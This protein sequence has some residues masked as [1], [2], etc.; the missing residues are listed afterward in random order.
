MKCL[1]VKKLNRLEPADEEAV[2]ALRTIKHDKVVQIEIRQPRNLQFHRKLF[3]M[4]RIVLDN[5]EHY[6]SVEELLDMCKIAIGHCHSIVSRDGEI[7]KIPQSIAFHTMD[8]TTFQAFYARV[9]GWVITE[10]IPGLDL[11]DLHEEVAQQLR[12][13]GTPE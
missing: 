8:N 3:A 10:A 6:Q 2:A 1:M 11:D 13:F 9:C 7:V 12:Q 4:L 5:Q